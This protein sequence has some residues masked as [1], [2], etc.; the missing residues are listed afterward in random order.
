MHT[1]ENKELNKDLTTTDIEKEK[2]QVVKLLNISSR[3][4]FVRD[5]PNFNTD[6]YKSLII[7]GGRK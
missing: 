3:E 1:K 2:E 7:K 4:D 6:T 5:F